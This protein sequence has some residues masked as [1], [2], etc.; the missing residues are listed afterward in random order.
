[1]D[2]EGSDYYVS[3]FEECF[4]TSSYYLGTVL[5]RIGNI[6]A[7]TIQSQ[8]AMVESDKQPIRGQK[9]VS[10]VYGDSI[11]FVFD[12]LMTLIFTPSGSQGDLSH[13][14]SLS[15]FIGVR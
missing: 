4:T 13:L 8:V 9:R 6:L 2:A 14:S 10:L 3:R 7:L 12:W 11:S 5:M 1:M 15:I